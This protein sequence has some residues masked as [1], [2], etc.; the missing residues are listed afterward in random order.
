MT[1]AKF[2][3][4]H[5]WEPWTLDELAIRRD[6]DEALPDPLV[7]SDCDAEVRFTKAHT[8][9]R[10]GEEENVAASIGL[11]AGHDH[12]DC[13]YSIR[14]RV[15]AFVREARAIGEVDEIVEALEDDLFRIRLG[16]VQQALVE[17]AAEPEDDL[18]DGD[19][20]Q[21]AH[22]LPA[23][24]PARQ[25]RGR[26]THH[27][28]TAAEVARLRATIEDESEDKAGASELERRLHLM[29]NGCGLSQGSCRLIR[30]I[31]SLPSTPC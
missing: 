5:R 23:P 11:K 15:I 22:D 4:G 21:R 13:R 18:A 3:A 14:S 20:E 30:A 28:S 1:S 10:G 6:A 29:H 12:I 16:S 17:A 19:V 25:V 26:L 31:S 8:R 9:N 24:G 27:L 7:C 2:W